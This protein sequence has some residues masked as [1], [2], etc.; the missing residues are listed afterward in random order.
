MEMSRID[1]AALFGLISFGWMA[2][3]G[4]A[5]T[6]VVSNLSRDVGYGWFF[7]FLLFTLIPLNSFYNTL[8]YY[9]WKRNKLFDEKF[10]LP[11]QT[12][13]CLIAAYLL[14]GLTSTIGLMQ[15]M[16]LIMVVDPLL[17]ILVMSVVYR[18]IVGK[19]KDGA[20]GQDMLKSIKIGVL[21]CI[22]ATCCCIFVVELLQFIT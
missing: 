20:E 4:F 10:Y 13:L 3:I 17:L 2:G 22:I 9:Y 21:I 19:G 16:A 11:L 14:G 5:Y 7:G 15:T 12:S 1:K 6:I 8:L 18:L